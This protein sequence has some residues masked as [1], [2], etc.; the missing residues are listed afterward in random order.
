MLKEHCRCKETQ[1]WLTGPVH[2]ARTEERGGG[3]FERR[4]GARQEKCQGCQ[5]GKYKYD[6]TPEPDRRAVVGHPCLGRSSTFGG[7]ELRSHTTR[8]PCW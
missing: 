2:T 1:H 3:V 7:S 5:G 8:P 6:D 4:T